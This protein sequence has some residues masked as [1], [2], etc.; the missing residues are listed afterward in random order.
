M[1]MV[2]WY[3]I[4]G[5][6]LVLMAFSAPWVKQL[7]ITTP[8]VYLGAGVGIGWWSGLGSQPIEHAAFLEHFT[9][10]AVIVS[11]FTAGL[12]LRAPFSDRR[13]REPFRLAI[14]SMACAVALVAAI[15]VTFLMLPLGVAIVLGAVLA[16]T[17]PV[18]ASD[19]QLN[20]PN[21]RDRLR[22]SLTGEAGLNDGTAFPFVMLGL[23]VIGVH[24]SG[25]YFWRWWTVD[26]LW[27]VVGGLAIGGL[28]GY[29][30]GKAVVALRRRRRD[31]ASFDDFLTLGLIAGSYGLALG[32]HA[33]GFL[34]VFAAGA[35]LRRVE[36]QEAGGSDQVS[37]KA[38]DLPSAA[39]DDVP[40]TLTHEVLSFNLKVEHM[41]EVALVITV[42]I[43]IAHLRWTWELV[44]FA[45]A[46]FLLVRPLSVVVGLIGCGT[47]W[48]RLGLMSWFGIRGIG[49]LYYLMFAITH[50]LPEFQGRRL[51]DL[52]LAVVG[53][54]IVVHGFSATPVMRRYR[55]RS[56]QQ[57]G[58]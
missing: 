27:A 50:G 9:E 44:A 1:D 47:P 20:D 4:A 8:M 24:P 39:P 25:V 38:E 30:V 26:L 46:M 53:A 40:S 11:L 13:W 34:A 33:Y 52:A 23:A 51:I 19:V 12:K 41:L 37:A 14:I 48:L 22:F 5:V 57:G 56:G 21:D 16:P 31:T 10:V 35:A 49:S 55:E 18:L 54:S 42:G 28:M 3:I 17:D 43:L 32:A 6:V 7:P 29:A 36:M 45:A 2:L 58:R 15:G